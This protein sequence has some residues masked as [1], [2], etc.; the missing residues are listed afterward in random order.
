M[1]WAVHYEYWND[2]TCERASVRRFLPTRE[3]A[4]R[5]AEELRKDNQAWD[6]WVEETGPLPQEVAL[7]GGWTLRY[8]EDG[9]LV[10]RDPE[11]HEYLS[12]DRVP[13][14]LEGLWWYAYQEALSRARDLTAGSLEEKLVLHFAD[15]GRKQLLAQTQE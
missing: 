4:L 2:A 3:E 12:Q 13:W 6:V 1:P 15:Q 14:A 5:D 11:G 8:N 9:H 7:R 10:L